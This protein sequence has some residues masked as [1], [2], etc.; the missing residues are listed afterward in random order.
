VEQALAAVPTIQYMEAQADSIGT[1]SLHDFGYPGMKAEPP[2]GGKFS[3]KQYS[4]WGDANGMPVYP[5]DL[6]GQEGT[7]KSHVLDRH[8]GLTDTQLLDRANGMDLSD[9]QNGS[10]GFNDTGSA[11]T[12]VQGELNTPENQAKIAAWL[13]SRQ[14][15]TSSQDQLTL[16]ETLPAGS[17]STGR[18]VV[19]Q[20]GTHQVVDGNGVRTVLRYN[21][22]LNPPFVVYTAFPT[23]NAS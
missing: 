6:L 8:V 4:G 16:N 1:R 5:V 9:P 22:D 12:L 23:R 3:T 7:G 17:G 15:G 20:N 13:A 2:K 10:S 14:N 18:V 11:Q 19:D 21:K